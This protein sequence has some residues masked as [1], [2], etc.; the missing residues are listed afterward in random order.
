MNNSGFTFRRVREEMIENLLN[1]G[2]KDFRVLDAISQ[3]PRHIFVDEAL[4]SRAYEN[5]S[6]TIGYKQTIS[7]PFIVARMTEL[8]ISHTKARGK[9]FNNVLELGTGCGYQ[10]AVLSYFCENIYS[11]ERIKPLVSKA[12]E[13]LAN[14]KIRNIEIIHGDGFTDWDKN[15]KYDG[16]IC[17][18]APREYPHELV[19]SLNFS[20]KIVLPVGNFSNQ[21]LN[22]ITKISEDEILEE[23]F[24]DVS[25]VPMLPGK[26]FDGSEL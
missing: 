19:D 4:W 5:R 18:A 10:S 7:Q 2:I 20:A 21:K 25:F 16:V 6:L 13:N 1:M 15:K 9:I 14:L 12:R 22:V 11:V 3:V 26:S 23:S 24:E 8:L 17:A